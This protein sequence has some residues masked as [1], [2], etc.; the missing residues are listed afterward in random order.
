MSKRQGWPSSPLDSLY[1]TVEP[2]FPKGHVIRAGKPIG[3]GTASI[4]IDEHS[5]H[6]SYNFDPPLTLIEGDTIV[7][8]PVTITRAV[9]VNG[10]SASFKR[11]GL[12]S[13]PKRP[14]KLKLV[15]DK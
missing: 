5:H 10:A 3:E 12:G 14:T 7:M 11:F 9:G 2:A 8:E 6:I 13:S 4:H 1:L 15:F